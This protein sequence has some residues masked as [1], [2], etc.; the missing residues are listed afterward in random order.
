MKQSVTVEEYIAGAPKQAQC[1][2]K[3]LRAIIRSAAPQAEELMS[4]GMPYYKYHGRLAYFGYFKD[5]VSLFAI[6][7]IA[8]EFKKKLNVT[9]K[10]TIRFEFDEKLPTALLKK[11]VATRAK[12]N[13]AGKKI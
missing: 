3:T 4:Y 7:P 1:Q 11:I 8:A 12:R 13:A 5:H 6:P 9:G 2:L 10:A